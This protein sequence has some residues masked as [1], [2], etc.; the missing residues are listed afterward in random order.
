MTIQMI[1]LPLFVEVALTF[2][3]LLWL[4]LQ[5]RNDLNS[6]AV[7]PSQIALARAELVGADAA[8]SLLL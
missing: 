2:A 1:L 4:G 7:H 3:L 5:R 8:S 6:G